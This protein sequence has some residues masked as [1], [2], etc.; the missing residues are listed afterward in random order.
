MPMQRGFVEKIEV[1]RAG[2]VSI[3]LI[4]A[5]DSSKGV[6][7]I[8]DLDSD[9]EQ[10]NE[11][12]SKLAILRDAMNRAEPV[13]VEYF[14]G[15]AGEEIQTVAR[16]S[17]DELTPIQEIIEV[18][19]L[20]LDL[21][22]YAE[23]GA[24]ATGEKHDT[25]KITILS[26]DL[27]LMNLV[28][29]LQAPE[30]LVVE[31]QFEMIRE[32]QLTGCSI[33][34]LVNVSN[35]E[36][37]RIAHIVAV[38]VD[39]DFSAF[40]KEQ[41]VELSGF[42]ESLSLISIPLFKN[43]PLSSNFASIR[44]TTAPNFL[45]VGNMVGTNPFNPVTLDL[46][47]PRNSLTYDLFEAGLRDNLRM[48]TSAVMNKR[49]L[50]LT[51]DDNPSVELPEAVSQTLDTGNL[52]RALLNP[53]VLVDE[54][55]SEMVEAATERDN[56]GIALSAE[57]MAPLSSASRP[58]WIA[59]A[60]ESLDIGP[61]SYQKCT[62]G[63]PSSDLTPMSLRDLRIPYPAAWRGFGC[64]N[65]GTYRFQFQL[66]SAFKVCVDGL[67]LCLHDSTQ[68]E[69]K[70]AHACLHGDHEITVEID[71]WICSNEFIMDIYRLR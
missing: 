42:V 55:R 41:T 36:N 19:G 32:A 38:A 48:R 57:L 13:E 35:V 58:V 70:L 40:N 43:N 46:L 1:G 71:A 44:F 65:P 11:R 27:A 34:F 47:V 63:L 56:F 59:I 12:L 68:P 17:R 9:P 69:I 24:T 23:N 20:V 37:M 29:N 45:G 3:S 39:K 66:P 18:S 51:A 28:L 31:Q 52:A 14:K 7:I 49:K 61:D 2:L 67:P 10:F 21:M 26:T 62:S 33:R 53:T 8:P 5:G 4:H 22:L 60:R 6:Y 25:A 54:K 15:E 30:R 50:T 64:F 16:V